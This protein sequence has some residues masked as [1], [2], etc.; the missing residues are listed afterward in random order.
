MFLNA[1]RSSVAYIVKHWFITLCVEFSRLM[2]E[3]LTLS[4]EYRLNSFGVVA[5]SCDY[6]TEAQ[7]LPVVVT[8]AE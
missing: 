6:P 7:Y 4:Q 3:L 8:S 5:K 2:L 1:L